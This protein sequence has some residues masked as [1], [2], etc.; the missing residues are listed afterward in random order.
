MDTLGLVETKTI[1]GGARL[2]DVLVKKADVEIVKAAAICSGRFLIRI[3][4]S[5][6]EVETAVGEVVQ[7][8][9]VV[10]SFVLSSIHPQVV[11][12]LQTRL[13]PE[14]GHALGVV[15]S[16]RSASGI[17]AADAAVKRA[18]VVLV[19]L[20]VAQGINGKSFVLLAGFLADVNEGVA[21]AAACLGRDLVDQSV[22]ARPE[23]A[24]VAALTG[25][26]PR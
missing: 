8:P 6:S 2:L 10:D 15:E 1:A 23:P 11:A 13:L 26:Q 21:A 25:M 22:I 20:A 3:C 12:A 24:T 18:D 7:D 9:G 17:A 5:R 14:A 16:R 4:G 19:R